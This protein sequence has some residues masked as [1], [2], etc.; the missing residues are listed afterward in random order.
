MSEERIH[1]V[2]RLGSIIFADV[3]LLRFPSQNRMFLVRKPY[4]LGTKTVRFWDGNRKSNQVLIC[5]KEKEIQKMKT[6]ICNWQIRRLT[7]RLL[8]YFMAF[9]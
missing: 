2:S 4:V 9:K 1:L 6:F 7:S 8:P 5:N 3:F